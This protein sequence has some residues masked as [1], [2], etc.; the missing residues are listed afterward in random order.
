MPEISLS[1]EDKELNLFK[2]GS[3]KVNDNVENKPS[4]FYA[5]QENLNNQVETI[6]N[7]ISEKIEINR[8]QSKNEE[9][10]ILFVDIKKD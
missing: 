9:H 6:L 3:L 2:D 4:E 10:K 8:M 1:F 5:G 7:S